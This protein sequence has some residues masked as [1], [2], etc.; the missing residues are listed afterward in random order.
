[1][2]DHAEEASKIFDR[3]GTLVVGDRL[4]FV[5]RWPETIFVHDVAQVL[6]GFPGDL[7]LVEVDGQVVFEQ[8][9]ENDL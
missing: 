4:R 3:F 8:Y 9:V 5:G 2:V 7:A 1:M 6:D